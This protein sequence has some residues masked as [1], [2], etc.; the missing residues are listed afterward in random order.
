MSKDI[1][2][3]FECFNDHHK[4]S[5]SGLVFDVRWAGEPLTEARCP[6]CGVPCPSRA[7]WDAD[8]GG[9]GSSGD[10]FAT[11]ERRHRDL[12]AVLNKLAGGIK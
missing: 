2:Y 5:V 1:W 3:A 6:K 10:K 9:Y 12:M 7:S 4:E 11:D 8:E